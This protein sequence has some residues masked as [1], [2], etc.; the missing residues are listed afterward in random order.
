MR[1][2]IDEDDNSF[3]QGICLNK[4]KCM[5]SSIEMEYYSKKYGVFS[6]QKNT[7]CKTR[8][9]KMDIEEKMMGCGKNI[10][11]DNSNYVTTE[12]YSCIP[13]DEDSFSINIKILEY[14]I[15]RSLSLI[16]KINMETQ[17]M[18]DYYFLTNEIVEI[19]SK[20]IS[21][22]EKENYELILQNI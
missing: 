22:D 18:M 20:K 13:Y 10:F 8:M 9:D 21:I 2:Y 4:Y 3:F 17:M 15:N 19:K 11:F 16:V 5:K 7:I 12:I 1:I 14:F 6:I